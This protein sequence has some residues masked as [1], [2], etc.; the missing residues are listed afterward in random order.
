M[1]KILNSLKYYFLFIDLKKLKWVIIYK[2]NNL[3][4]IITKTL[5]FLNDMKNMLEKLKSIITNMKTKFLVDFFLVE[6][7][8][9]EIFKIL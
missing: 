2:M 8:F 1:K 6:N 9:L 4:L 5:L 3:R 7:G